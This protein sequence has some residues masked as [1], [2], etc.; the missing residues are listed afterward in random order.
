MPEVLLMMKHVPGDRE[1][2]I[3]ETIL[4]KDKE[5]SEIRVEK[6]HM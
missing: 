5:L 2:R 6:S 3:G 1:E 4:R